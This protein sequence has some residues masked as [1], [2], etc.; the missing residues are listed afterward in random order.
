MIKILFICHGNICRSTMCESVFTYMVKEK[1]IEKQFVIDSGAT[2][3]EEIGNPPHRGTVRKLR[4]VGIPL[5]PHRARQITWSDYSKYD[6]IIGMDSWNIRNINR[7]LKGDPEGKVYK[8]LSFAG[9]DR[10]IAD[11][12]YTGNFDETYS[13]IMEGLEGFLQYLHEQTAI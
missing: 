9:S 3:T 1:G 8:L 5:V 12:W 7:M 10:D 13:D 6:Y 2:S 11:P 4:E